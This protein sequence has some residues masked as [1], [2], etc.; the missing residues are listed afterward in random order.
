MRQL[1]TMIGSAGATLG[2]AGVVFGRAYFLLAF[3][4][5]GICAM[6]MIGAYFTITGRARDGAFIM[7]GCSLGIIVTT[8]L[9]LFALPLLGVERPPAGGGGFYAFYVAPA[10]LMLLAAALAHLLRDP[11]AGGA[12][13]DNRSTNS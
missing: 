1:A 12:T 10:P 13:N 9:Y 11:S 4:I 8:A 5:A 6:A 3:G 2:L 7:F